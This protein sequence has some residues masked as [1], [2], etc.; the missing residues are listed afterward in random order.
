MAETLLIAVLAVIGIRI[1]KFLT[2]LITSFFV[3]PVN[4]ELQTAKAMDEVIKNLKNEIVIPMETRDLVITTL[5]SIGYNTEI[6]EEDNICFKYQGATF[7]IDADNNYSGITIWLKDAFTTILDEMDIV[8][9]AINCANFNPFV[10]YIYVRD[11]EHNTIS[12]QLK[13]ELIFIPEIPNLELYLDTI[14]GEFYS[15]YKNIF[16]KELERL[17]EKRSIFKSNRPYRFKHKKIISLLLFN[18]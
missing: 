4:D 9:E 11:E 1:L 7:L 5:E 14:I 13:T 10:K 16:K 18:Q 2:I 6:D 8:Q 17:R 15:S 3:K 12:V